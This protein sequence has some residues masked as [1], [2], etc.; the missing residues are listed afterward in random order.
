MDAGLTPALQA[1]WRSL[2]HATREGHL[3]VLADGTKWLGTESK[4]TMYVR[5]HYEQLWDQCK[6]LIADGTRRILVTGNP[7]IGKSWFGLYILYQLA[8]S[9]TTVVWQRSRWGTRYLFKVDTVAVGGLHDFG[10]ELE[11][12]SVMCAHGKPLLTSPSDRPCLGVPRGS[13]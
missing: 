3:L 10:R 4:G 13:C 8:L 1:F 9:G 7:G 2:P 5:T 6:A 11:G 12:P